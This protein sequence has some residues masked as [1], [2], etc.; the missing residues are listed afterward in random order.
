MITIKMIAERAN[1]SRTTV[2]RVL[3]NSGYVSD[4]ARSR[5]LAVIEETGY[6]PSENAKALRTKKTKVVGVILPKISTETSSRLVRGID[7][8]LAKDGYQI[9]LAATNLN[10]EKEIE[11]LK[12][13]KSRNVDG[14]ILS[15]TNTSEKL[16]QTIQSLDLPFAAVGQTLPGICSAVYDDEQV[17]KDLLS[18]MIE[19]GHKQIGFIG[20][21]EKDEA[22]GY[23]RKKGYLTMMKN[24]G[25]PIEENWVQTA[26]FDAVSGRDAA[27]R[28]LTLSEKKPT[29]VIAVTDRLAVGAMNYLKSAGLSV[30]GDVA[31]A[32]MG[33]S[34]MSEYITPSLT[35]VDFCYEKAG[36]EAAGLILQ[37]IK[38][39]TKKEKIIHLHYRLFIRESI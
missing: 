10:E 36:E 2:S 15:A 14:I 20:V 21:D 33:S 32:G 19:K 37:E 30:P 34:E 13:L 8:R 4:E 16:I 12:L 35:T 5:V 23:L 24:L 38:N 17:T 3:N 39:E 6:I 26:D 11:Y 7:E 29:A 28:M 27:E 18:L 31:I 22:V 1:V 25:L 9:L